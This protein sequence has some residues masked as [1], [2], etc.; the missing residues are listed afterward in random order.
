MTKMTHKLHDGE[1]VIP[2]N[3]TR[4][5]PDADSKEKATEAPR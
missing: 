5:R 3:P 4:E 2:Q 1:N